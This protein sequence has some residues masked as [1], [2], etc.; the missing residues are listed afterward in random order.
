[1]TMFRV[2]F[3]GISPFQMGPDEAWPLALGQNDHSFR[4]S[5]SERETPPNLKCNVAW[6]PGCPRPQPNA[7][8]FP[9]IPSSYMRGPEVL[10]EGQ[11]DGVEVPI[12]D[13]AVE[14]NPTML[15]KTAMRQRRGR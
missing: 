4:A 15:G 7:T 10:P 1:M 11:L 13:G 9:Y 14:F 3:S 6:D 2:G 5:A 12:R 8:L